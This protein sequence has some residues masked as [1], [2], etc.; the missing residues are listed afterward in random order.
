[1]QKQGSIRRDGDGGQTQPPQP[2][3]RTASRGTEG[4]RVLLDDAQHGLVGGPGVVGDQEI[5]MVR[6]QL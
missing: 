5:P 6:Q 2:S 1:M 4:Q 3:P